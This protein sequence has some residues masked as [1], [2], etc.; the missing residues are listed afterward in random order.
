MN[1]Y[2]YTHTYMHAYY[3]CTYMYICVRV[4]FMCIH[5]LRKTN[6]KDNI[7]FASQKLTI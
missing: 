5:E 3:I 1:I 4:M 2:I 7:A 6:K